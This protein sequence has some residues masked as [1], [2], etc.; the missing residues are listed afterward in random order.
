MG[1][2]VFRV[3]TAVWTESREGRS[4]ARPTW[5]RMHHW[6]LAFWVLLGALGFY[7]LAGARPSSHPMTAMDGGVMPPRGR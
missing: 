4:I 6:I 2:E 1:S 5:F 7:Q 3:E